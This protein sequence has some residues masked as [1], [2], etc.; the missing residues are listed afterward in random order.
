M[1]EV[2]DIVKIPSSGENDTPMELVERYRA[3]IESCGAE[4]VP[5]N[6]EMIDGIP[7]N[8]NFST[9]DASLGRVV[10]DAFSEYIQKPTI[11]DKF[12]THDQRTEWRKQKQREIEDQTDVKTGEAFKKAFSQNRLKR[13]AITPLRSA[14]QLVGELGDEDASAAA[15]EMIT[16]I[17]KNINRGMG[18][19]DKWDRNKNKVNVTDQLATSAYSILKRFKA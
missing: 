10:T 11:K 16:L 12:E 13:N 3:E 4:I 5:P 8:Y 6:P 15:Q 18:Q 14:A 2:S 17:D 1:V 9:E 7:T 19:A